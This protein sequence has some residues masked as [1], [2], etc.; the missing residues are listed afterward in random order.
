MDENSELF[1][2]KLDAFGSELQLELSPSLPKDRGIVDDGLELFEHDYVQI[3]MMS[4][5]LISG[6]VLTDEELYKVALDLEFPSFSTCSCS[7]D[8]WCSHQVAVFLQVYEDVKTTDE[9]LENWLSPKTN[10]TSI[11]GVMRASDL[12]HSRIT[13]EDG[14]NAWTANIE[15]QIHKHLSS[16]TLVSNPYSIEFAGRQVLETL[17]KQKPSKR[18]WQPLY[19]LYAHVGL[20]VYMVK[21]FNGKNIAPEVLFRSG[22]A[23]LYYLVEEAADAAA[24]ISVHA[25]P[26]EFDDYIHYLQQETAG[27]MSTEWHVF[28]EQ[29]IDLYRYLWNDLFKRE[30]WRK[31]ERLRLERQLSEQPNTALFIA[32]LHQLLLANQ[33]DL[34]M[35]TANKMEEDML[36]YYMFWL[37]D[38]FS[39]KQY[40]KV[41]AL[42]TLIEQK[43]EPYLQQLGDSLQ[44]RRFVNWLLTY[45]DRDWLMAK[46]PLLYRSLLERMLPFSYLDLSMYLLNLGQIQEWVEL[47]SWI[48]YDLIELDQVGL[49]E[50]QKLAPE[51]VL[52]LYHHG[53]D[54]LVSQRNRDS[55]KKAVRYLKRLRTLY[56]KL[57]RTDRWEQYITI[58]L[59]ETKRLRAFQE[60]CR[61]GK[62]IDV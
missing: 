55:Y 38:A 43:L 10:L 44:C 16:R 15:K 17:L 51:D 9:W 60:E 36:D 54:E 59:E 7:E 24:S 53:I 12:L 58:L 32:Y 27:M 31:E 1:N 41:R 45:C 19:E 37:H 61:K 28:A 21:L 42:L 8:S 49:K 62:L 13:A 4:E 3:N 11:P 34:F 33:L 30:A 40:E 57:K 48:N 46:E 23:F 25:L 35:K 29:R 6:S 47:Q 5:K 26:F 56:K 18:E 50:A 20:F 2:E 22:T 14:P 52:P 39:L